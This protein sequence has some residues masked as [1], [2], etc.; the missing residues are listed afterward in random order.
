MTR[1]KQLEVES[2]KLQQTQIWIETPYRNTAMLVACLN[3]LA[4]QSMLCLGMDLSLPSE[5]I[6][7][8]SI[9]GW[10]KRYPNETACA[11]L[12]NR[13]AVFLLLA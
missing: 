12:Q 4:P 7:T 5:T 13:P 2:R 8:L 9:E 1:L 11:S 3:T 10:R 6:T